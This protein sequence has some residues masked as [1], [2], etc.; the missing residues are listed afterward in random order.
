MASHCP[1][2]GYAT[3]SGRVPRL[4]RASAGPLLVAV[5]CLGLSACANDPIGRTVPVKGQVTLR[6]QPLK[7]GSVVFWPMKEKADGQAFEAAA[8][9]AEDGGYELVTRGKPGAPPGTYKVTVTAQVPSNP[10]DPYSR[11][12][13][14]G[15]EKYTTK[16]NTPLQIDVVE[17][18][19]PGQYDLQLK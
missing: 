12:K 16:E 13:N 19:A 10:K 8:Q 18:P 2:G 4:V 11:A 5:G 9:I 14:L 15:P 3:A 6:G 7:L 17:N 1:S